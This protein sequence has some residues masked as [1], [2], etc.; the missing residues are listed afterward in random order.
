MKKFV[1]MIVGILFISGLVS[2]YILFGSNILV[3]A[4]SLST[5]VPDVWDEAIENY[6]DQYAPG[7]DDT[8]IIEYNDDMNNWFEKEWNYNT[9]TTNTT[10][11]YFSYK[12]EVN[13]DQIKDEYFDEHGVN[14]SDLS[15]DE[16][17]AILRGYS[18]DLLLKRDYIINNNDFLK[19][20]YDKDGN[21][22]YPVYHLVYG[23]LM[24]N[25]SSN[26]EIFLNT[27]IVET[28]EQIID[29][30]DEINKAATITGAEAVLK[31]AINNVRNKTQSQELKSWLNNLERKITNREITPQ[32]A[33]GAIKNASKAKSILESLPQVKFDTVKTPE[34][35]DYGPDTW[36][37]VGQNIINFLLYIVGAIFVIMFFVAG[38][39]MIGSA[40]NEEQFGK[41]K[42][43]MINAIIGIIV[44]ALSYAIIT[45]IAS[46]L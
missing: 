43:T 2:V 1:V 28:S 12:D 26:M 14:W 33:I 16:Q 23:D 8:W 19:Y 21:I 3:D 4:S 29:E 41:G 44:V 20:G 45:F 13:L 11:N 31:S 38:V 30:I 42:T 9:N 22:N 34:L 5:D 17:T 7:H 10:Y 36:E 25:Y 15:F 39:M 6:L 27:G 46:K 24:D 40:G 32:E 35:E 37:K 18:D